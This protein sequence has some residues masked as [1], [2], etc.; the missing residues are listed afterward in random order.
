MK[1]LKREVRP[2]GLKMSLAVAFPLL[3]TLGC[4]LLNKVEQPVI[5]KRDAIVDLQNITL[6]EITKFV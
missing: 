5:I 2:I 4:G 3:V 6:V 1:E